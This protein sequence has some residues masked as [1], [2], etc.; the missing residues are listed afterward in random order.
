M[1]EIY[2]GVDPSINS[3]GIACIAYEDGIKID[4]KFYIIK[5]E[6]LTKKESLAEEENLKIFEYIVYDR[7]QAKDKENNHEVEYY[8]TL[9]AI[10]VMDSILDC[11][12][13]FISKVTYPNKIYELYICQEGISYGSVKRTK[14]VFDLA[15]LNYL[16]RNMIINSVSPTYFIIATPSEIK[17]ITSGNGNCKK[18]VM[19]SLFKSIYPNLNLPKVDDIADAYWMQNYIKILKDNQDI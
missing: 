14:S 13:R 12:K 16:L 17:K 19:V 11:I 18:E 15:G 8:K 5:S 6:K 9:S 4:E 1:I 7:K 3:S 10:Q 2:I